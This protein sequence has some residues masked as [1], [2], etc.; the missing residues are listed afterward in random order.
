[1][2]RSS[3]TMLASAMAL[4]PSDQIVIANLIV[5]A[6]CGAKMCLVL[7]AYA[8][9]ST[10]AKKRI[11]RPAFFSVHVDTYDLSNIII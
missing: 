1:M 10:S 9:Q 4:M 8:R 7:F 2:D 11:E 3:K 6:P 5:K